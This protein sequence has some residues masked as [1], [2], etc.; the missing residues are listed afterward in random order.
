MDL[1]LKAAIII[2]ENIQQDLHPMPINEQK[3]GIE[4]IKG[5]TSSVLLEH[6]H[7]SYIVL[8]VFYAFSCNAHKYTKKRKLKWLQ[9]QHFYGLVTSY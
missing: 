7:L 1:K 4:V 6:Q 3:G 9:R 2:N 8:V 5:I